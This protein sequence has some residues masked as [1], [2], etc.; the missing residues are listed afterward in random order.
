MSLASWDHKILKFQYFTEISVFPGPKTQ[1]SRFSEKVSPEIL[2]LASWGRKILKFQYFTEISVFPCPK[3]Q[4]SRFSEKVSP[5]ILSLASW[6]HKILK[7]QYFTEISVF[8]AIPIIIISI[9]TI[10]ILIYGSIYAYIRYMTNIETLASEGGVL[11]IEIDSHVYCIGKYKPSGNMLL[12]G[13]LWKHVKGR[14]WRGGVPYI[15]VCIYTYAYIYISPYS[16]ITCVCTPN[17]S[18]DTQLDEGAAAGAARGASLRP[19]SPAQGFLEF[20]AYENR[21]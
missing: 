7:F 6:D 20:G 19:W 14:F 5:E 2:S 21:F 9:I 13:T 11:Y 16:Y 18:K 8:F 10:L 4:D 12:G 1:D 3:T 17:L 15:Y